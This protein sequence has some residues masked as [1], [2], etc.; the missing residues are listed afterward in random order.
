M[1]RLA[2]SALFAAACGTQELLTHDISPAI[3]I[4]NYDTTTIVMAELFLVGKFTNVRLA[5]GDTLVVSVG[6]FEQAMT[7]DQVGTTFY[8]LARFP[9]S[10]GGDTFTVDLRRTVDAG[11]PASTATL[12]PEFEIDALAAS[13]SRA[14]TMNI[15]WS[16]VSS[17][18]MRWQIYGSCIQGTEGGI[19]ANAGAFMLP[20]GSLRQNDQSTSDSCEATLTIWRTRSG[21][22][23]AAF[24][25]TGV[26]D[27]EQVRTMT[28]W[29]TP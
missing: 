14:Q 18:F 9:R 19:G 29:T 10:S 7:E 21:S 24:G 6:S 22:L 3:G 2:L 15:S 1:S 25:K 8:Y 20:G 26:I 5:D 11:A 27:A 12:P 13:Q 23:D 17:D 4:S 16:N 28:F